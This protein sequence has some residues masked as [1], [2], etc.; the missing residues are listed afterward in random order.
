MNLLDIGHDCLFVI[1]IHCEEWVLKL[2]QTCKKLRDIFLE[3]IGQLEHRTISIIDGN[4]LTKTMNKIIIVEHNLWPKINLIFWPNSFAIWRIARYELNRTSISHIKD[5][6]SGDQFNIGISFGKELSVPSHCIYWD[7]KSKII[8]GLWS[9]GTG[10]YKRLFNQRD[11]SAL[12]A[13]EYV[14]KEKLKKIKV[15]GKYFAKDLLDEKIFSEMER[16]AQK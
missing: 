9:C 6:L 12:E 8:E 14:A 16:F 7:D 4:T 15:V 2:Q 13:E 3:R 10:V 11:E 5:L 1:M